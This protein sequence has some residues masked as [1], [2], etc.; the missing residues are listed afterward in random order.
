MNGLHLTFQETLRGNVQLIREMTHCFLSFSPFLPWLH[1]WSQPL[2]LTPFFHACVNNSITPIHGT[3]K[4]LLHPSLDLMLR[5]ELWGPFLTPIP[6]VLAPVWSLGYSYPWPILHS[7]CA[8]LLHDT[9]TVFHGSPTHT[10]IYPPPSVVSTQQAEAWHHE[11]HQSQQLCNGRHV[12]HSS[13]QA[14][15][16]G[17]FEHR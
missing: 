7:P 13:G 12:G 11:S 16:W 14:V 6:S 10:H 3:I 2:G 17:R 4:A 15:R 1:V 9:Q 8:P 5:G